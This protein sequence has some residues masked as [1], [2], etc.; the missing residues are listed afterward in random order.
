VDRKNLAIYPEYFFQ[1]LENSCSQGT[2]TADQT[3][4]MLQSSYVVTFY[5]AGKN[6]RCQSFAYIC[7]YCLYYVKT[8]WGAYLELDELH[9]I[10]AYKAYVKSSMNPNRVD[11]TFSD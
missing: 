7:L 8:P 2:H 10:A 6:R 3:Q 5:F 11:W 9:S 1:S 4:N